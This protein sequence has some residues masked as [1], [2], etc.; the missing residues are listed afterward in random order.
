MADGSSAPLIVNGVN[1]GVMPKSAF[2]A[3]NAAVIGHVQRSFA[4]FAI[5]LTA[6]AAGTITTT[7]QIDAATW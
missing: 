5:V 2:V 1:Y 6:I 4:S 3:I 7:A